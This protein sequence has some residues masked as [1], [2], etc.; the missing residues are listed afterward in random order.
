MRNL[1]SEPYSESTQERISKYRTD[2]ISSAL[3][4][5][6]RMQEEEC[7]A[8]AKED[9]M[10]GGK[11]R[12]AANG[13]KE[14]VLTGIHLSSY[15]VDIGDEPA[16]A[17][18]GCPRGGTESSVSVLAHWNRG[19]SRRNLPGRFL[20]CPRCVHIFTCPCKADAMRHCSR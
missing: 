7:E 6:S 16:F 10:R 19:S 4:V 14:V 17:D 2:V 3:T 18:S 11:R 1:S 15:G 5:L 12:L 20:H 13:Y 8:G 9:V